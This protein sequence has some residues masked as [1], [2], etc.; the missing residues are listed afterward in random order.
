ML[1]TNTLGYA[2]RAI[3]I[4]DTLSHKNINI[5]PYH[6]RYYFIPNS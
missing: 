4:T 2:Y 6:I 5:N 3:K 1:Y